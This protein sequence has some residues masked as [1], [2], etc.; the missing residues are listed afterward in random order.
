MIVFLFL[1]KSGKKHR[2]RHPG[3]TASERRCGL[4]VLKAGGLPEEEP[5]IPKEKAEQDIEAAENLP[6]VIKTSNVMGRLVSSQPVFYCVWKKRQKN[7][8]HWFI[9]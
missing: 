3:G 8:S 2:P 4:D 1:Q 6:Y 5:E 9:K 7:H